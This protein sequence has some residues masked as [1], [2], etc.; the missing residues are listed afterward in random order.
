MNITYVLGA[1][2]S[3]NALPVVRDMNRRISVFI[4]HLKKE[5]PLNTEQENQLSNIFEQI[6]KHYT[7]DTYAKKLF[8]KKRHGE[9]DLFKLYNFMGAYFIYEQ[10]GK[11]A[12]YDVCKYLFDNSSIPARNSSFEI[13][14]GIIESVDYRYDSFYAAILVN[15]KD[16]DV[17]LPSNINIVSW[18]Y[19]FQLEISFMNF[20]VGAGLDQVQRKLRIYPSPSNEQTD[21]NY[22]IVKINGTAGLF[23]EGNTYGKLFDFRS[24]VLD[25]DAMKILKDIIFQSRSAYKNSI[26]FAW[27]DNDVTRNARNYARNIVSDADILV[28]IGYSFPYF[29]R[30]IDRVIFSALEGRGRTIYIQTPEDSFV[31]TKHRAM[32]ANHLFEEARQ[33]SELDQFLIP[34]EFK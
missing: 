3:A 12:E 31:S 19:D 1:G 23:A 24:H 8:L 26:Y 9:S 21:R 13:Y 4:E 30:D 2:A 7:I 14:N 10:L 25:R 11:K 27:D 18:N 17:S 5:C 34:N 32:G 33:F 22:S 20:M 29:N 15:D 16:G 28:V 6:K